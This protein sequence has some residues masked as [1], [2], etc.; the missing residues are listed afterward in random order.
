MTLGRMSGQ[1]LG[2]EPQVLECAPSR[3]GTLC[4][5]ILPDLPSSLC[6]FIQS[7]NKTST[8][9]FPIPCHEDIDEESAALLWN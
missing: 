2:E 1:R 3:V 6:P 5:S 4:G 7:L 9:S 8:A